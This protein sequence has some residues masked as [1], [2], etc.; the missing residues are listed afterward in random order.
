[1]SAHQC[2]DKDK[3]KEAET[4]QMLKRIM[5]VAELLAK[6]SEQVPL[7]DQAELDQKTQDQQFVVE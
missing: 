4:A 1:V 3:P 2:E 6:R 7:D 5:T